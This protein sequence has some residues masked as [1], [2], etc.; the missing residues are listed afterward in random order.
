[1]SEELLAKLL[2]QSD[3]NETNTLVGVGV[4]YPKDQDYS[5]DERKIIA[6]YFPKLT[7][8]I[9]HHWDNPSKLHIM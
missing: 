8:V 7:P 9:G 2:E 3:E 5:N 1:L 4:Y 6:W